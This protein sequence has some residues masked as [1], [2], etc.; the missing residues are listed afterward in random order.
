MLLLFQFLVQLFVQS[1][2]CVIELIVD[3]VDFVGFLYQLFVGYHGFVL[4]ISPTTT[5]RDYV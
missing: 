5:K 3:L 1:R 4:F 2:Y